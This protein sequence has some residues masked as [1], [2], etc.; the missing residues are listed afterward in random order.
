MKRLSVFSAALLMGGAMMTSIEVKAQQNV[1]AAPR[2]FKV[3]NADGTVSTVAPSHGTARL[4]IT[5]SDITERHTEPEVTFLTNSAPRDAK[6]GYY[7]GALIGFNI[8]TFEGNNIRTPFNFFQ[9]NPD[10]FAGSESNTNLGPFA[11]LKFGYVWPF[12]DPI[13]QF[14][15]ETGGLRLAGALEAE[16]VYLHSFKKFGPDLSNEAQQVTFAPM[17]NALL[18]AYWGRSELY[19]GAGV[20]VASTIFF[21][22][23]A[24]EDDDSIGN[25]AHQLILGYEFH[26]NSEWSIFGESKYFQI[27]DQD[28]L[29][30]DD[31][32]SVLLG[33]G[34]KKQIF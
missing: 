1:P 34:V 26:M 28:F 8:D 2:P 16:L 6:T 32:A 21:G 30:S 23:G 12:G 25:F 9:D 11:S 10:L 13:D 27:Q 18:K 17:I 5:P 33:F 29:S 20:G 19:V 4:A 3:Q 24:V 22:E 7:V 14:E 15:Q 31:T